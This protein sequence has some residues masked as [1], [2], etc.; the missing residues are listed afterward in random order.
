MRLDSGNLPE[1]REAR[2]LSD[3]THQETPPRLEETDESPSPETPRIWVP[4]GRRHQPGPIGSLGGTGK[5]GQ[6]WSDEH[7]G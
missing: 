4:L 2:G 6:A 7:Q 5:E 1:A 3:G